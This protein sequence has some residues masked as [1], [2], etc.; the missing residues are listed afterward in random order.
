MPI[1]IAEKIVGYD[2]AGKAAG[3]PES[4][5]PKPKT[6]APA[7]K[8]APKSAPGGGEGGN[9]TR[10]HE[11]VE[12]P[13]M[14]VGSTYKIRTP[15]SKHAFYITIND[16]ILNPGTPYE[17]RRPFE[18]F[19]N[20]KNMDH[21]QWISALT[22][23]VSAVF[24]KG[25]DVAFLVQE[26]KGVFDPKGGYFRKGGKYMPSLV[27]EIGDAIESHLTMI[28]L[29]DDAGLDEHQRQLVEEK[30][31]AYEKQQ[32]LSADP[33]HP[34]NNFPKG[35]ELCIVCNTKAMIVLDNCLTC[36]NCGES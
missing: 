29:L 19:I 26:L 36:L 17:K 33:P 8:P 3:A 34:E 25:G 31:E 30:R 2:I 32:P 10:M 5:P 7:P 12:R 16:I 20:S 9:I 4:K 21:Y 11:K 13:E 6:A 22:L 23:I 24:R 27:A 15:V 35:A 1:K 28:G 14:L 18:M